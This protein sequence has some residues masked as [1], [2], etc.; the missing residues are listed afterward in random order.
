[1]KIYEFQNSPADTG[2]ES[3]EQNPTSRES[4]QVTSYT[5][6]SNYD[7][8]SDFDG[9]KSS[10]S[11]DICSCKRSRDDDEL[12]SDDCIINIEDYSRNLAAASSIASDNTSIFNDPCIALDLP[13][14]SLHNQAS[15]DVLCE[16]DS[17]GLS[18]NPASGVRVQSKFQEHEDSFVFGGKA[19]HPF[20]IFN[21]V[22]LAYQI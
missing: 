11:D 16:T 19:D 21:E 22:I 6:I 10:D 20:D 17:G 9:P 1:M 5:N 15:G 3:F 7:I 8:D 18:C 4:V 12:Y 13:Y 2:V 14:K